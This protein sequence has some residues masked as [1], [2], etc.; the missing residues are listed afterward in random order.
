MKRDIIYSGLRVEKV[1]RM[2]RCEAKQ[3]DTGGST[4]VTDQSTNPAQRCL[5][6][7]CWWERVFSTCYDRTMLTWRRICDMNLSSV[8][9]WSYFHCSIII[10][11]SL[12]DTSTLLL[13][14]SHPL[15][16]YWCTIPIRGYVGNIPILPQNGVFSSRTPK[17]MGESE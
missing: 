3:S 17:K 1:Q 8:H 2:R 9:S 6:S 7:E 11:P 13:S 10:Q 16:K 4:V 14:S 12:F 15:Q 5:T